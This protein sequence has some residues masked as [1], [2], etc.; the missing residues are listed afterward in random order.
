MLNLNHNITKELWKISFPLMI[1]MLSTF[2][3][4]FVDR[5]FLSQYSNEALRAAVT[6]GTFGWSLIL[7]W[8][9]LATLC[10][11]F[12]A[13]LN[14]AKKWNEL[15]DPVWQM[16]WL[17]LISLAFFLPMAFYAAPLIYP[18]D[19]MPLECVYFKWMMFTGPLAVFLASVT[20]FYIGQGK[21]HVAKWWSII[22][23]SIN[24][25]FDA[26]L[27]FGVKGW[28]PKLGIEG[29]AIATF[30]GYLIEC[31]G[32]FLMFVSR[33]NRERYQSH[34]LTFQ[35]TLM[36][37]CL[38]VGT[39]PA[40]FATLEVMAWAIFY[41]MMAGLSFEHIYVGGVVQSIL[42]LFIFFGMGLEKG[43]AAL[44]GNLIGAGL[45]DQVGKVFDAGLKIIFFYTMAM[46][47][48]IAL[49]SDFIVTLFLKNP[50]AIES[51]TALAKVFTI[52]ELVHYRA[53][54]KQALF[55]IGVYLIFEN[56]RWLLSGLLTAAGDTFFLML[57][58]S[59]SVW[60]FLLAPTYF[61]ICKQQRSIL[62]AFAVWIA[63][64]A[65]L[66]LIYFIRFKQGK[67]KQK[68]IIEEDWG[69]IGENKEEN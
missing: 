34:R 10:E 35:P 59:T 12:V 63:Y 40:I 7:G 31:I 22:G 33:S 3:M 38:K 43:S 18:L 62:E 69:N 14:G 13:Q 29:A 52:E 1:A 54:V 51:A 11:V 30:I 55:L 57:A 2:T 8:M 67:W 46:M 15:A 19:T 41:A 28:I 21:S 66:A 27:I 9:T 36:I 6:A 20:A 56:I 53:I 49:T 68:Q 60:A 65:L 4:L 26:L 39:P 24:I 47:A 32:I 44:A 17:S 50:E 37:Q 58:G 42:F 45:K 25:L 23:N 5:L 64:S 48:F 61:F 16:I